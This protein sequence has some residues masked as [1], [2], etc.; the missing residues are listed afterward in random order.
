MTLNV[1]KMD[2][3]KAC[4][5]VWVLRAEKMFSPSKMKLVSLS[6]PLCYFCFDT[7]TVIAMKC[8]YDVRAQTVLGRICIVV[9]CQNIL[10]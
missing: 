1:F 9:G 3:Y 4:T 8:V 6:R 10:Y 5:L 2:F 7:D